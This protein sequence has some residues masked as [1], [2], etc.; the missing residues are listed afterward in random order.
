[1]QLFLQF[2][3][4]VKGV[5][6]LAVHLVDEDDDGCLAHSTDF[7]QFACLC[8]NTFGSVNDDNGTIDSSQ[9]AKGVLGKIL[10]TWGIENIDLVAVPLCLPRG[11]VIEFHDRCGHAYA[12]LLFNLHPV[13]G[14][15]FSYLVIFDGTG[16]LNLPSKEKQ[17]LCERCFAGIGM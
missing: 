11:G 12:T 15:G 14:G 4:E 13:A 8:L 2:I 5:F 16:H 10:V 7:H 1:M 6:A 9:G 17:L 3:Q